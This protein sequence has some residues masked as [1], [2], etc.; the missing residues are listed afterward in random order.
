MLF[1]S[2]KVIDEKLATFDKFCISATKYESAYNEA[3][4]HV[5][6][7]EVDVENAILKFKK[8]AKFN[9]K[10]ELKHILKLLKL[11][12][13]PYV[14]AKNE[15]TD[16]C[17]SALSSQTSAK[18][19]DTQEAVRILE[20]IHALAEEALASPVPNFFTMGYY[21]MMNPGEDLTA[22]PVEEMNKLTRQYLDEHF[23]IEF[24]K[25][26]EAGVLYSEKQ[27]VALKK[28]CL[29]KLKE[30]LAYFKAGNPE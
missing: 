15:K 25:M 26:A 21:V 10:A 20:D 7:L 28:E 3:Y 27:S 12:I 29:P 24:I 13:N 5:T 30:A 8:Q 17:I 14:V 16:S 18:K 19:A 2:S 23:M 11:S 4:G 9:E 1:R 6:Q 22:M